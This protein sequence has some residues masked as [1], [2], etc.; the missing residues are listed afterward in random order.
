MLTIDE[1]VPGDTGAREALLDR[2]FG[3]ARFAKT[4]ERLREGRLPVLAL[5]ARR[6]GL[7]IGTARLW[8]VTAGASAGPGDCRALLLG[9]LAV[10]PEHQG[11]GVGAALMRRALN[12][13]AAAG[14]G[15]VLLVGDAPYYGRFGF[16]AELTRDLDM[17]GPV[18][19][20]RF[21]GL[22]LRPGALA[23]ASGLLRPAGAL[24]HARGRPRA[25]G[26]PDVVRPPLI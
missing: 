9:P 4:S 11:C 12:R 6:G 10:A 14:H 7:L 22:E 3:P 5:S 8:A 25:D 1:E 17:P 15:A 19:R 13:A 2:A 21:L 26:N 24:G 18:E 20:H 16:S 23:G